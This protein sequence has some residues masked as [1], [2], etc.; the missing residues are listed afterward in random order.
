MTTLAWATLLAPLAAAVVLALA[1]GLRR[2]ANGPRLA[3][4]SVLLCALS[5]LV[6]WLGDVGLE[7]SWAWM[8][9]GETVVELGVLVDPLSKMMLLVV[10]WVGSAIF[11]FALGY[12]KGDPSI[13]RL[14]AKLALFV[15]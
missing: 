2:S 10:G 6:F 1:P 8:T 12:M 7:S 15:F 13:G 4:L 5:S 9:L 11:V 3:V 14:F